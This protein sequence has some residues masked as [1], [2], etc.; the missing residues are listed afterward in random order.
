VSARRAV[1]A[2]VEEADGG[3][4]VA[5][6]GVDGVGVVDA[7]FADAVLERVVVVVVVV[8]AAAAAESASAELGVA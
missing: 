1:A 8:V 3:Y 2:A 6:D 5:D 7:A 4:A